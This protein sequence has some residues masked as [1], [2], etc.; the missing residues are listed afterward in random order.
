[1]STQTGRLLRVAGVSLAVLLGLLSTARAGAEEEP[2]LAGTIFH[3]MDFTDPEAPLD[4]LPDLDLRWDRERGRGW[5]ARWSS[6]FSRRAR[7]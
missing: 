5:S 7:R 6:R 3:R 2:V 4:L 1:M